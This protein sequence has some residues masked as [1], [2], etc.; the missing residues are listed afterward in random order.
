MAHPSAGIFAL[1]PSVQGLLTLSAF[2]EGFD[3]QEFIT[4]ISDKLI[5]QS[6]ED[7]GS[8]DPAPFIRT[9]ESA[10]DNLLA[11]REDVQKKKD[12]LEVSVRDA[13]RG[14]SR[15]IS[16]LNSGFEAVNKSF[17]S[18][19]SKISLV[20]KSAVRTGETLETLHASRER[21]HATHDLI[22]YYHQFSSLPGEENDYT[23]SSRLKLD[24]MRRDGGKAGRQKVAVILRRLSILAREV[25]LPN[26]EQ[27]RKRIE[28]YC[29]LFEKDMLKLFDKSYRKGD[30]K[31]MGHCAQTLLEFNGGLLAKSKMLEEVDTQD[32]SE[33]WAT[34]PTP[35][36]PMPKSSKV[37]VD[38]FNEIRFTVGQE[39]EIVQA[40][41]PHP[42][43]V[44]GVFLQ[45]VFAQCIQ[46]YIELLL[47]KSRS[48]SN[49]AYLR[50]LHL[51]HSST[52]KLIEDLKST[53]DF[54]ALASTLIQNVGRGMTIDS[55]L[56]TS[57]SGIPQTGSANSSSG[58][59]HLLSG[60]AGTLSIP[61]LLDTAM[62]ELFVPYIEGTKYIE[63]ESKNL[64]ELYFGAASGA[65]LLDKFSKWHSASASGSSF[66]LT[67]SGASTVASSVASSSMKLLDRFGGSGTAA[68]ASSASAAFLN[69]IGRQWRGAVSSPSS[70][71]ALTEPDTDANNG[72][73]DE[74]ATSKSAT[75][76][77]GRLS[78]D[79][80]ETVLKWHAEAVGRCVELSIITDIPKNAFALMKVLADALIKGYVEVAINAANA[81]LAAIPSNTE[82]RLIS[83]ATLKQADMIVHLWQQYVGIA[84]L[85]LSH[86]AT[87]VTLRR[88]MMVYNNQ[89]VSR[90]EGAAA[91][92]VRKL[93]DVIQ[94]YLSN[95]LSKQK[96]TDF[97]PKNDDLSFARVNTEPCEL[98]CD[99]LEK[100]RD[101]ARENMSGKNL[102]GFLTEIG[103]GFHTLLLD[104]M[105]KFPVSATGGLMLAKDLKSYQDSIASFN[106]PLLTERFE[107]LRQLGNVFLVRPEIL[108]TY[109]RENYL[110]RIDP[111]L[112]RPYLAMRSDWSGQL[113]RAWDLGTGLS[114]ETVSDPVN[115]NIGVAT[116]D[117][118][119]WANLNRMSLARGMEGV[120]L[121]VHELKDRLSASGVSHRLSG[122]MKDLES[123]RLR[124]G[125]NRGSPST[126]SRYPYA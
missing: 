38:L 28:K 101:A 60:G 120:N 75:E 15:K 102:E 23:T 122:M 77:D 61:S 111:A 52:S 7:T 85:P 57:P 76:E 33:L 46:Q 114:G 25:D 91:S 67:G 97:K 95:S 1:D 53:Y 92:L 121:H 36:H 125:A 105:K 24:V 54:S 4:S 103:V 37:L 89:T 34:L 44:M 26:A 68:T 31:M 22:S 113:E 56:P 90:A 59:A 12:A 93:T 112:I 47:N 9:F 116:L 109:I 87:S 48:L 49:L 78:V 115:S 110:G 11:I 98:C 69:N 58:A 123:L 20:G 50:A 126:T 84:L 81:E 73:V 43:L 79:L 19:H 70:T 14:F 45:R 29:E 96:K 35:S 66:P 99:T 108:R 94:A 106:F 72:K 32:D 5:Q 124:A 86:T 6:K 74:D 55:D 51:C 17:N 64:N 8:F 27:T 21:A 41:F 39:N 117:L 83:L 16:E 10:V 88:E 30:P 104:H 2:K 62:E 82:P 107:F 40:V 119:S 13:E 3:L 65:G 100:V 118:P 63:R 18:M 42:V 80:A 71:N